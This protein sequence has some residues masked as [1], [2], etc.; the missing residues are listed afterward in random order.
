MKRLLRAC[1]P[2][3]LALLP[4]AFS[5]TGA[6]A[7]VPEFDLPKG[8]FFTQTGSA[9][10]NLGFGVVDDGEARFWSEFQRLGGVQGVGYP[11]SHRFQWDGFL[12]QVMQKG[13][14]QWRPEV[15]RAYFVNVFDQLASAGK[16]DWLLSFRS[17]PRPLPADFDAGKN[18]SQVVAARLA[19]LD[20]NPAIKAKYN[21]VPDP[22]NL[23]GLPTSRVVDNGDHY[24]IRLQRA[25]IQQWKVAVPWAGAG[26][27]TVANGGEVGME[28]GLFPAASLRAAAAD[29][30]QPPSRGDERPA[31]PQRMALDLVNQYRALA[32]A[33]PL[34]LDDRLN[35]AAQ[36][37]ADYYV[38]NYGDPSLAGM[39][40]HA[41][42]PGRPGFT[43]VSMGDR[44][45]AAGYNGWAVDENIGL[46]GDPKRMIDWCLETVN[47]RWNL[48]HP[49]A[50][51]LGY[52][53]ATAPKVDVLDIGFS[54]SRPSVSLPTVYPGVGQTGVPTAA[55]INETPDPAP[56]VA[57]P[58]GYPITVSFHVQ[59]NVQY[60]AW[61]LMDD[62]G[63]PVQLYTLRKS[64]LRSLALIPAKPL[65]GGSK[66]TAMVS[67]TVNGQTFAKIWSFTTR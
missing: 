24:V 43:G 64:W 50:A 58:L 1:L 42:S 3:L 10:G 25:V 37:H 7:A 27:V 46:V 49:S 33:A 19:L 39:G 4:L 35:K 66:Y 65:R 61:S 2:V 31:S 53:I 14:L 21:A 20:A 34:T 13:V 48:I 44:A 18:W 55:Y 57:R 17:T 32:G 26:Q 5:L 22:M 11:L 51:N 47:H 15:G 30:A 28:A 45:K 52:G 54:G 6:G 56:G 67:G 41:E 62:A 9:D 59:D 63:Q 38:R 60:A 36:A 8:R 29:R 23:Y 12:V 40:L 16:D